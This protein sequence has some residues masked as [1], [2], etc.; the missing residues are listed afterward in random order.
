MSDVSSIPR[1][2]RSAHL[3]DLELTPG[4]PHVLSRGGTTVR[5]VVPIAGGRFRGP[6]LLGQ[7]VR[8]DDWLS[9]GDDGIHRLSVRL[10]L[11]TDGGD[12]VLMRYTG[13]RCG[14]ADVMQRLAAGEPVDPNAYYLRIAPE[15]ETTAASCAWLN[16]IVAVGVGARMPD[17]VYYVVHEVL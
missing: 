5:T 15:F 2:L 13:I 10:V 1:G 7:V 11:E 17:R 6:R 16:G 4:T 8:G 14:P 3:F 9:Y 12:I